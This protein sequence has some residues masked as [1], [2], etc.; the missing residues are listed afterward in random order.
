MHREG[1]T[2][3]AEAAYRQLIGRDARDHGALSSLGVLLGQKS[4]LEEAVQ[5]FRRAVAIE[6]KPTYL[7]Q[8]GVIY[9]LAGKLDSAAEAFGRVFEADPDFPDAR[10]N[11]ASVLL[12]AGA[13]AHALPLL[14]QALQVGPDSGR[15]R[16]AASRAYFNLDQIERALTHAKRAVELG[17][18]IASHHGRL[19]D[20]LDASGEKALA[21]AS[22]RRAVEMDGTDHSVHSALIMAMLSSPD[23]TPHDHLVEARAWAERHALPLMGRMPPSANDKDPSAA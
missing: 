11:L 19:A 23:C 8:L 15:L 10:L 2:T 21:I 9:R 6:P 5:F 20:A 1:R 13:D 7:T 14:E 12:D 4:Q 3:E 22:Y 17:P 18:G 16:A